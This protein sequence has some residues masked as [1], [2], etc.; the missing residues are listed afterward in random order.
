MRAGGALCR[1]WPGAA[2][3]GRTDVVVKGRIGRA[4]LLALMTVTKAEKE[5]MYSRASG[6]EMAAEMSSNHED[7]AV[8]CFHR[9]LYLFLAFQDASQVSTSKE[10]SSP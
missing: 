1:A 2:A 10:I 8:F 5:V 6:G 9:I 4:G 3:V 7:Q